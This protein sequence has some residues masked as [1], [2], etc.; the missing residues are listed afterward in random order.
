[1][2]IRVLKARRTAFCLASILIGVA[3]GAGNA[4]ARDEPATAKASVQ[5]MNAQQINEM[6]ARIELA[7]AVIKHVAADAQA[8]GASDSWRAGLLSTLYTLPSQSLQRITGASTLDEAYAQIQASSHAQPAPPAG[9]LLGNSSDSLVFTPMTPCRYVDTRNVGGVVTG[10]AKSF[11]LINGGTT[12]GGAIGCVVPSASVPAL[13]ANIT[14]VVNGGA[15]GYVALAPGDDPGSNSTSFINF[16]VGGTP[17]LANAGII[18]LG[19]DGSGGN[20]F[21]ATAGGNSAFLIVDLF[22]Y[23]DTAH[24]AARS[25]DCTTAGEIVKTIA[26]NSIQTVYPSCPAGYEVTSASCSTGDTVVQ[27]IGSGVNTINNFSF[28]TWRNA[29]ANDSGNTDNYA[30]CC[31]SAAY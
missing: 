16:P 22:G 6:R 24:S 9:K 20:G 7:D 3:G 17:G 11:S 31:R 10:T 15:A 27:L 26:H 19:P 8:K 29:G 2:N 25:L 1:M 12:Y 30:E 21:K 18:S 13:A 23:F 28:C 4:A 5:P 14:V